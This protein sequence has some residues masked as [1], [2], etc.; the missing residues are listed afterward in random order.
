MFLVVNTC[1]QKVRSEP[2]LEL[3]VRLGIG[4]AS[5]GLGFGTEKICLK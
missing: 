5:K 2:D 4:I 3:L 1:L